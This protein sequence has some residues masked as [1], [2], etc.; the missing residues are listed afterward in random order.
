[1]SAALGECAQE[2]ERGRI[3]PVK[4]L[5]CQNNRLR[6]RPRQNPG[7]HR[8]EL[9]SPQLFRREIRNAIGRQRDV[10]ERCKQRGMF[11]RIEAD[12]PQGAFKV[13]QALFGGHI[14]AKSLPAP[15]DYRMQRGILQQLRGAPFN[16]GMRRLCQ[17]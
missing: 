14:P 11:E 16:P 6:T 4:V 15:F 1:M 5:E 7:G 9:P 10:N 3:S 17:A 12:E 2:V 13:A 8:R